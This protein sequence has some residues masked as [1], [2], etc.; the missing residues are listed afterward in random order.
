MYPLHLQHRKICERE[1]GVSSHLLMLVPRS[2]KME[3]IPS[4]ETS[5]HT[6]SPRRHIPEDDILL[7][8]I[9]FKY[10]LACYIKYHNI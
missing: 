2:L 5:V 6:R 4:S 10:Y 9:M 1:T 3:T 8:A 7:V